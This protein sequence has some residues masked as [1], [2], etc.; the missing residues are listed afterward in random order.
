LSRAYLP[1]DPTR[2]TDVAAIALHAIDKSFGPSRV[3]KGVSLDIADGEFVSLV[4]PSGCGKTTLLRIIA[5][6][7][8]Q[9]AGDVLIGARCVDD[10][11]PKDRDVA[12]VFQSY[13]LYPY[14][15]VFQ[16][17]ALPL[18]MRRLTFVQRLPLARRLLPGARARWAEIGAEVEAVARSLEIAHL[19]ERKPGQLS[20][21]QRQRV[22]LGRAM[23]RRPAAFLMD[24]PLSNLDA[25]LRVAARGEIAELH[26]RLGATFVYVTH[27]QTEAMTMSDRVALMLGGEIVQVAPPRL[28]YAD[29]ADI[30]VAE[31]IGTPR[32]NLL[33]A[34]VRPD[35]A[36]TL[37]GEA[38]GLAVAAP[39]GPVTVGLRPEALT[40]R[41]G[42]GPGLA[43]RVRHVEHHGADVFLHLDVAIAD[44]PVVLRL[45]PAL[46]DRL[47]T[48]ETVTIRPLPGAALV[49]GADGRRLSAVGQPRQPARAREVAYG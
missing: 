8:A 26:R 5:G 44:E 3:L 42:E 27:D 1:P 28:L 20:G 29:P 22:A 25:K 13:A 43:A 39:P 4:G 36:V 46:F 23:V 10:L 40:V 30:R 34:A 14:M 9:D 6:L 32:I 18:E 31:F 21:G 33:R 7:E 16:N 17:M 38:L 24:E 2:E 12:M 11:A 35:G 49:F 41:A 48:D 37:A 47:P 19:L 45:E 15:S